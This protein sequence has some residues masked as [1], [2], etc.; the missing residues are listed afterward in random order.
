[1]LCSFWRAGV[2]AK[3]NMVQNN[4]IIKVLTSEARRIPI[5][6]DIPT[7]RH[8]PRYCLKSPNT[9]NLMIIKKNSKEGYWSISQSRLNCILFATKKE[10]IKEA[11]KAT[12]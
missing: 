10:S 5:R 12:I 1:M 2:G 9:T 11:A 8:Q 7:Y 6:S 4:T 3:I